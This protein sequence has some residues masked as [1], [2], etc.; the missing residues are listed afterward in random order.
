[1]QLNTP[2]IG[3]FERTYMPTLQVRN[4]CILTMVPGQEPIPDGELICRDG[5]IEYVGP[6]RTRPEPG[7]QACPAERIDQILDAEGAV[8]IPGLVNAH[9][10]LPMTLL[11]GFADDMPLQQW[12]EECI[13][14]T[15][16]RL[17]QDG[18]YW[19]TMLGILETLQAGITCICD[20]Y[21]FPAARTRAAIDGGLRALPSGVLLQFADHLNNVST[22][23]EFVLEL[24]KNAPSRIIPMLGPHAPYSCTPEMLH[25]VAEAAIE[26][27]LGVH[28]H[29]AETRDEVQ[30][31]KQRTGMTPVEYLDSVGLLDNHVTAAHCVHV[32]DS[33]V[34]LLANKQI[35]I[36]HC[37][38]SNMKLASGFAP[39]PRML[40]AGARVGLGTDG[41][42]SN[43]RLD[44]LQE[45]RMAALIHKGYSADPRVVT[46]EQAL[47][48]ATYGGAQALGLA[49]SIGT[50]EVG[51]CADFAII[52]LAGAHTQPL[53]HLHSQLIYAAHAGDVVCTVVDGVVLYERG[54]FPHLDAERIM[55]RARE[56]AHR[57][58]NS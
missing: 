17:D 16:A 32:T 28:I 14:P 6:S 31:V 55:S 11:R 21:H 58:V 5:L 26:H 15:E 35:G 45:A 9:T 29:V 51:K 18:V 13:W 27:H 34:E 49:D 48:M 2:E 40:Q 12:L 33:E 19:G 52:S 53:H 10:H 47:H 39:V 3:C 22:A 23:L 54:N 30:Q 4:A 8:L 50:L 1:M 25:R 57:L 41:A 42:A 37:P 36:V 56:A 44:V 7:D 43:N 38:S 46:S 20:M 24:R